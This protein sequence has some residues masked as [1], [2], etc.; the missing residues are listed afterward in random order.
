MA[1]SEIMGL[2]LAS[3]FGKDFASLVSRGQ[4]GLVVPIRRMRIGE[5]AKRLRDVQRLLEITKDPQ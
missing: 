4:G 2:E 1:T 5:A 3:Q